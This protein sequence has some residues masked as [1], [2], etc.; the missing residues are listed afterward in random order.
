MSADAAFA[1]RCNAQIDSQRDLYSE[2]VRKLNASR[3]ASDPIKTQREH[4]SELHR[5]AT[6]FYNTVERCI[7]DCELLRRKRGEPWAGDLANSAVNVLENIPGFYERIWAD[8]ARLETGKPMPSSNAFSAMQSA[9][10]YYN[11]DQVDLLKDR[12]SNVNLPIRGFTHPIPMNVR[13]T[14]WEKILMGGA[15]MV[16]IFVLLAIGIWVKNYTPQGFFIFR[17]VLALAGGAF[18]GAFIPGVFQ[19]ESHFYR[20]CIRASG[21]AAFFWII[22]SFNPPELLKRGTELPPQPAV[23][24]RNTNSPAK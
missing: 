21:A 23:E 11:P 16:I 6:A 4:L 14:N 8:A 2:A 17:V 13:Y 22:Y 5:K 10:F 12:F 20:N 3:D 24:V 19:V 9:V 15:A 1:V 7:V 18:A